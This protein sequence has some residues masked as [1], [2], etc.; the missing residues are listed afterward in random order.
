[1]DRSEAL[2]GVSTFTSTVLVSL[3][4]AMTL[5]LIL[6]L[7]ISRSIWTP[8]RE[9]VASARAVSGG[10]RNHRS[11]QAYSGELERLA[12]E[13][14]SMADGLVEAAA[15]DE[16]KRAEVEALN[17]LIET[18]RDRA[19]AVF[20]HAVAGILVVAPNGS[21]SRMN[22]SAKEIF[23]LA[24]ASAS[25]HMASDLRSSPDARAHEL[26]E[27]AASAG[28]AGVEM[29]ARRSG[30]VNAAR[31]CH[32]ERSTTAT[33]ATS[34]TRSWSETSPSGRRSN[35]SC[36]YQATHD[37]LT[38]LPN[39]DHARN[40]AQHCCWSRTLLDPRPISVLF[41]DLDPF[42]VVNDS[43]GHQVGDEL[44]ARGRPT[45]ALGD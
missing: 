35:N 26:L 11:R 15:S 42:K 37:A 29:A 16:H 6:S 10:D 13:V 19:N 32:C 17:R 24:G 25:G 5:V 27:L 18:E 38:G 45:I 23:G 43:R 2:L 12:V 33:M 31:A 36:S 41:V 44:V 9:V 39:R 4:V 40:Q 3:L 8:V 28:A 30:G 7:A 14:D 1:M 20:D 21:I 22:P 34:A